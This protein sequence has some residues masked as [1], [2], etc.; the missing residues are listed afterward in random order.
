MLNVESEKLCDYPDDQN[1]WEKFLNVH[2]RQQR[3]EAKAKF[4]QPII[5][6]SQYA[7]NIK[8]REFRIKKYINLRQNQ[9]LKAFTEVST[10]EEITELSL[11]SADHKKE[12]ATVPL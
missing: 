11:N 12:N 6:N 7:F 4:L 10:K 9:Y 1:I 3:K 8:G 5:I 2:N